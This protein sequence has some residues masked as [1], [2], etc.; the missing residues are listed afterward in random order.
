MM[1]HK[2]PF[3]LTGANAK[4][5][6]NGVTIAFISNLSYNVSI[7]HFAPKVLGVYE[8]DAVEP[9]G[10][11]ITGQFSVIRYL[12]GSTKFGGSPNGVSNSGN[13]VGSWTKYRR[14]A[15]GVMQRTLGVPGD[16]K[17]NDGLNPAKFDNSTTFDI[18]IYQK[19]GDKLSPAIRIRGA[20]ITGAAGSLSKREIYAQ[21][22]SF[23]AQYFDDDSTIADPS[24]SGQF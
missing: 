4:V 8:G 24:G 6:L 22:F 11:S 10:Y 12:E 9:L 13:G 2:I 16:N 18:E 20:R 14:N 19:I 1:S 15:G 3:F 21:T 17:A 23:Q 5:K 7:P